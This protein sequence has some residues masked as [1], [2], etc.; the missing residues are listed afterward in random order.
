[1]ATTNAE[2]APEYDAS[3]GTIDELK[4]AVRGEYLFETLTCD[5]RDISITEDYRIHKNGSSFVP[6]KY[7]MTRLLQTLRIPAEFGL[8]IPSDLLAVVESRLREVESKGVTLCVRDGNLISVTKPTQSSPPLDHLLDN[9]VTLDRVALAHLSDRGMRVATT[10]ASVKAEPNVGDVVEVGVVLNASNTGGGLPNAR[11]MTFQLVCSN[12]AVAGRDW[13]EAKWQQFVPNPVEEFMTK[14]RALMERS[15]SLARNI[16]YLSEV[17]LDAKMFYSTWSKVISVVKKGE[18]ADDIL[19]VTGDERKLY[20]AQART[21]GSVQTEV[22]AFKAFD[23]ITRIA[24]ALPYAERGK[25]MEIAG[26]LI[27]ASN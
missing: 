24:Q 18:Y 6:T 10:S 14:V 11:L 1:M 19:K 26:S 5:L 8:R 15:D 9:L 2:W 27:P 3:F 23:S 21:D 25:M 4:R 22:N 17:N 16:T 20:I 7:G 13:G 12:G